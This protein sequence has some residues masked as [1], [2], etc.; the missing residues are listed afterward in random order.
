MAAVGFHTASMALQTGPESEILLVSLS[1]NPTGNRF[2]RILLSLGLT[3]RW[4]SFL[5]PP[6]PSRLEGVGIRGTQAL[7]H[8]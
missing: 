3:P 4:N 5:G 6:A 2:L 7:T 1:L 8:P